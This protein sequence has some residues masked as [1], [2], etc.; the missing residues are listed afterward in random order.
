MS[1]ELQLRSNASNVAIAGGIAGLLPLLVHS[2]AESVT[3]VHGAVTTLAYRDPFAIGGGVIALALGA[4]GLVLGLRRDRETRAIGLGL[5]AIAL[6]GFQI[7][8]GFGAF[9]HAET[10]ATTTTVVAP[11]AAP[12]PDPDAPC[13][14]GSACFTLAS[15]LRTSDPPHALAAFKRTCEFQHADGCFE[16]AIL[17][18]APSDPATT[19]LYQRACDLGLASGCTNAATA[20]LLGDGVAKD[21]ARA[22][23]MLIA[24]CDANEPLGC[25]NA[26]VIYRDG[27]GV[28]RDPL[29]TRELAAKACDRSEKAEAASCTTA[30]VAYAEAPER[31]YVYFT[32]ACDRDP[33]ECHDLAVVTATGNGAPKDLVAARL[34]YAKACQAKN[35]QS[36]NNLGM[37]L[38]DGLGGAKDLEAARG[39]FLQACNGGEQIGCSNLKQK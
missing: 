37:L 24:A 36:C 26:S 21:Q 19:A 23:R 5:A 16:A 18:N 31:A 4:L 17:M 39:F 6:G 29:K 34:L 20:Y 27:L 22:L 13:E 2:M 11:H 33:A 25:R 38:R 15:R 30:G 3:T 9:A 14:S 1:D 12:P 35:M 32:K 10:D 7:A 28:A 8:R